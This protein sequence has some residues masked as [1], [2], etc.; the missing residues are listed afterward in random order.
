MKIILA[1]NKL[2]YIGLDERLPWRSTEDLQHFKKL[3]LGKRLLVG[4]VTY[5]N[6]P[7]LKDRTIIVVGK[8]Y[9]TLAEGLAQRP[10]FIIG[11]KNLIES[12]LNEPRY[13][14]LITQVHLSIIDDSTVG[15]VLAPKFEKLPVTYYHFKTNKI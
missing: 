13:K 9:N 6:L 10:D 4:R 15:D 1:K 5:E 8:G 11:G 14:Q 12:I 3:T 7:K 2:N